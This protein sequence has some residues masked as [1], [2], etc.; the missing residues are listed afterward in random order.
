M[1]TESGEQ[2]AVVANQIIQARH[3]LT[4]LQQKV[5]A[6]GIAQIARDDTDFMMHRLSAV[7]FAHLAGVDE[8]SGSVYRNMETITTSLLKTILEIRETDGARHRTKFQWL[9]ECRY[10][11]GEGIAEI[12]FHPK[13]K[14][15]LLELRN[16]FTQLRLEKFFKFRSS[17]TIRFY[18]LLVMNR[19]LDRKAWT[20]GMDELR[21]WLGLEPKAYSFFGLLRANVLDVAQRELDSKSDWSFSFTTQ[22]EGRKIVGVKF[23]ARPARSPKIDPRQDRWKK[24]SPELRVAILLAARGRPRWESETDEAILSDA[25]FLEHIG[26]LFGEV[27]AGQKALPLN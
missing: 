19:G 15:Y 3:K 27:E 1:K 25:V 22:K 11:D 8:R 26:D 20:M 13:L 9:A 10:H 2:I 4:P 17:Y 5:I 6:W 16:R 21:E 14:P 18:E 12:R 23:T 7:E 24:A